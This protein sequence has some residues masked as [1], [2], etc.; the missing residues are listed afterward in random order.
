MKKYL[1]HLIAPLLAL[2]LLIAPASALTV[3]EALDLLEE[4]YYYG[5]PDAAY[6]AATLD[7]LLELLADPYTEY[8]T[9]AEYR[10]FLGLMEHEV[11]TVGIGVSIQYQEN[12]LLIENT[13]SGG[14]AEE[15]G[16]QAGDLI[17]AVDG[18][19]CVP[20]DTSHRDLI[21]G[22]EGTQVT[23]TILRDGARRD[24]TITRRA[25]YFPNTRISLLE[26][27]VGYVDCDSFGSDTGRLFH[28]GLK[29][30]DSQVDYWLVDLR[31]NAGG[32]ANAA[33]SM[34]SSLNGPGRYLYFEDKNGDVSAAAGYNTAISQKPLIVLVDGSSA[35]ASE[36]LASGVR[37]TERGI[38][39]GSRTYG[40]GVAQN[41]LDETTNPALFD[42]DCLKVTTNRFYSAN[43][44]TTDRIGVIPTLLVDDGYAYA[45]AQALTSGSEETSFLCVMPHS[46]L[47]YVDPDADETVLAALLA[48]LPPQMMLFYSDGVFD[49]YTPAQVAEKLGITYANRWF[50]DV[51]DSRYAYAINAL[52][53]YRLL[54]GSGNGGFT[55]NA[56]LTRAQLCVMLARALNATAARLDY[57][58]DVP[59]NSWYADG[60]NAIAELGLVN[61]VGDG[62][63]APDRIVTQEEF[64]TILGRAARYI[65][66][67]LDKY[68]E[69][70]DIADSPKP[71]GMQLALSAYSSWAKNNVAVLAWGLNETTDSWD[72]L[73][74]APLKEIVPTA[75]ILRE[76]AAAGM[77]AVLSGLDILP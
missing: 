5:V 11:S 67:A 49:Q 51:A 65:N 57:F 47:F 60:V 9:E 26:G 36:I 18:V 21:Q 68:G 19:S 77:Y 72:D 14:P 32:Y 4:N 52:G 64:L 31:G 7:E 28:D 45:V 54:N 17:V 30:Y 16:L 6:G 50:N 66:F 1:S 33:L 73:L 76:E 25:V 10:E 62:K 53:A 24:F 39:V 20:A 71:L 55:P 61:G 75:P 44:S 23:V 13:L 37:D 8:M 12:G 35:S 2:T 40:K 38:L 43:G 41:I 58:T 22:Q 74:Y 46:D 48:A 56:Q 15:A 70:L 42:G 27:G 3:S 69:E 29:Q 34:I 63:F 59:R